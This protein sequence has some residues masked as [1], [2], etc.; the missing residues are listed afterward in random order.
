MA[1]KVATGSQIDNLLRE[2]AE[3]FHAE[4]LH[5]R[6]MIGSLRQEEFQYDS[7]DLGDVLRALTA[8][9]ASQW[10]CSI[11]VTGPDDPVL[12][13]PELS[14]HIK[15]LVREAIA[16]AVQHGSADRIAVALQ[17]DR[18]TIELTIEDNGSGF[19]P[20]KAIAVPRSIAERVSELG[21]EIAVTSGPKATI[22]FCKIPG[23]R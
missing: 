23:E 16:N 21:G 18:S 11:A 15:Q 1:R 8:R 17:R 9:L 2:V 12:V 14:L 3:A 4:Q 10:Q 7:R 6:E 5:V 22:L 19:D 13:G 20:T